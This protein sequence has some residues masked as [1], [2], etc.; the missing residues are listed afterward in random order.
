MVPPCAE[1]PSA[2]PPSALGLPPHVLERFGALGAAEW[3][4][5]TA[6]RRGARG[7]GPCHQGT[8]GLGRPSLRDAS[9]GVGARH[10]QRPQASGPEHAGVVWG[11]RAGQVTEGRA[12]SASHKKRPATEGVPR[13]NARAEPP[14]GA[15]LVACL[16]Q[17]L[18]SVR[19]GG[20]R[21]ALGW[22][23]EGRGGG[24][25]RSRAASAGGPGP[26]WPDRYPGSHAAAARLC[27]GTWPS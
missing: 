2:L 17:A 22:E 9:R 15:R 13:V 20:D 25:R 4:G 19:V 5:P 12:G 26:T 11:A 8:T 10:W 18:A 7:P 3:Q 27:G 24:A 23:D 21:S 6:L 16:G 14:S 1:L